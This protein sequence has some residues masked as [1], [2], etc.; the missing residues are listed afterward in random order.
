MFGIHFER[1]PSKQTPKGKYLWNL[2]WYLLLGINIKQESPDWTGGHVQIAMKMTSKST[3]R[4][5]SSWDS[6]LENGTIKN[7]GYEK[8]DNNFQRARFK[9][10]VERDTSARARALLT[11]T[12]VRHSKRL[13]LSTGNLQKNIVKTKK[14]KNQNSQPRWK[15]RFMKMADM[16]FPT[17]LQI[18]FFWFC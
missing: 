18:L 12:D 11:R 2:L 8:R 9:E 13:C 5:L 14:P 1:L 17:R 7:A 10:H 15:R 6:L 4:I 3:P 16:R